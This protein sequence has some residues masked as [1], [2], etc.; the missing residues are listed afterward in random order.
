MS[1]LAVSKQVIPTKKSK[2][3]ALRFV[4]V[5]ECCDSLAYV[6]TDVNMADPLTKALPADCYSRMLCNVSYCLDEFY[7]DDTDGFLGSQVSGGEC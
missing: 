3:F 2:H 7:D 4:K 6:P 1:T 5:K